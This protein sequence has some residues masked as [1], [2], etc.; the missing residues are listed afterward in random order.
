MKTSHA[1]TDARRTCAV[2]VFIATTC[3]GSLLGLASVESETQIATASPSAATPAS[4]LVESRSGQIGAPSNAV[5]RL[6]NRLTELEKSTAYI[7][8]WT[9]GVIGVLTII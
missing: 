6:S 8:W 4:P 3:A 9:N 5:D 2:V 1:Y 7:S